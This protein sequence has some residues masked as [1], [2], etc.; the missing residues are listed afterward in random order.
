M[1]LGDIIVTLA[2]FALAAYLLRGVVKAAREIDDLEVGESMRTSQGR[3][4]KPRPPR[5]PES[6]RGK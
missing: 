5:S 4:I 6:R 1:T 2:G 3:R